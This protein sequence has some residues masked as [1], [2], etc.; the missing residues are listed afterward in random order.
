MR[1][2]W[3]MPVACL[4][5]LSTNGLGAD[6]V[7]LRDGFKLTGELSVDA[8]RVVVNAGPCVYFFGSRQL[9][10]P[11]AGAQLEP[12]ERFQIQQPATKASRP[13]GAIARVIQV[14]SFDEH[15][16]RTIVVED[17]I[18]RTEVPVIQAISEVLPTHVVLR[19]LNYLW[20]STLAINEVPTEVLLATLEQATDR[21]AP[22]DR[23][24]VANFFIQ[25]GRFD[26]AKVELAEIKERFPQIASQAQELNEKLQRRVAERALELLDLAID[27]GQWQ[28]AE[29]LAR[30]L[31]EHPVPARSKPKLELI[32]AEIET[33]KAKVERARELLHSTGSASEVTN[34]PQGT[35]AAVAA[36]IEG[37][38]PM[39]LGRL[40]PLLTLADQPNTSAEDRLALAI[41]GWVLGAD[42]AHKD[43]AEA[44]KRWQEHERLHQILIAED[45]V[46]AIQGIQ[47]LERSQATPDLLQR[48]IA[49]L[50]APPTEVQPGEPA[51]V[52]FGTPDF[53]KLDYQVLLPPE[54]D[55]HH[56]YP[57]VLTLHGQHTTAQRQLEAWRAE[58]ARHGT[59]VIAPH[60]RLDPT[61]PYGYSVR[62]HTVLVEMLCDARRRFAIDADR[63]FLSG[64]EL[65]GMVAWDLGMGHPDEFAGLIPF[66]AAPLFYCERYVPNLTYLPV[67]N[68]EGSLNGANPQVTQAQFIRYFAEGFNAIYVEYPGRGREMFSAEIP[69]IFRWMKLKRREVAPTQ[70]EAVSARHCDRRF[71]WLQADSFHQRATVAPQLFHK[72]RFRPAEMKGRVT[73]DNQIIIR[74]NGLEALTVLV[75]PK[76]VHLDDPTLSIR[77]N[78]RILHRGALVPDIETMISELRRTGDRKRLVVKRISAPRL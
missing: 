1:C 22:A 48:M 71:Y 40:Q 14:S 53:D 27:V 64:H 47:E 6:H 63:V 4:V 9:L 3:L 49:L 42:L 37:L 33:V 75:P 2:L 69:T 62:E 41:S 52:S 59:I 5:L 77:A 78:S 34:R 66:A 54:Y 20:Q 29:R 55:R 58:A 18:K 73:D 68:V 17:P 11:Q 60:W 26:A 30:S 12:P 13:A 7:V 10:E 43:L 61:R 15:G 25:A 46:H 65:G 16:R 44:V 19:G 57:A 28:R 39:T 56:S 70:F 35:T 67:Y 24:R 76:L 32:T 38:S 21:S 50:P 51:I 36:M 23:L 31:Q 45:E 72:S 8:S 74:T